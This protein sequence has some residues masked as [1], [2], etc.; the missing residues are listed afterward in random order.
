MSIDT[1]V[2]DSSLL[3][4]VAAQ[5][6]TIAPAKKLPSIETKK[7]W[8]LPGFGAGVRV[9]TALGYVPIEVLRR[10]DPIKTQGHLDF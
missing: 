1:E 2:Y 6:G 8:S 7:S 3:R 5:C 9:A 10:G 4:K